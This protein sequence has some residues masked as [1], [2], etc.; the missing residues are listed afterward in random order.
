MFGTL[1][2]LLVTTALISPRELN[3]TYVPNG[4]L[5]AFTCANDELHAALNSELPSPNEIMV[6][7]LA[8]PLYNIFLLP[9]TNGITMYCMN[10]N[11]TAVNSVVR[12]EPIS[13]TDPP[14][15]IYDCPDTDNSVLTTC[16]LSL[17]YAISAISACYF[18]FIAADR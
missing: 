2:L 6:N 4:T 7:L 14:V 12:Y 1:E 3:S 8:D 15:T 5:I 16:I 10:A 18:V 17:L 11:A 13:V 9:V